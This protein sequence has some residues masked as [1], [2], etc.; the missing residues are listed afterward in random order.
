MVALGNNRNN[1]SNLGAFYLNANNALGNSNGNNWRSRASSVLKQELFNFLSP[2]QLCDTTQSARTAASTGRRFAIGEGAV[3]HLHNSAVSR[4]G[5][6]VKP[7]GTKR[8]YDRTFR[9][10]MA[11]ISR[12]F[13]RPNEKNLNSVMSYLGWLMATRRMRLIC[14]KIKEEKIKC[15]CTLIQKLVPMN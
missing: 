10:M 11:A 4:A 2:S 8:L 14:D 6:V 9:R 7:R 1:G 12:A 15:R 3:K 13:K 5:I